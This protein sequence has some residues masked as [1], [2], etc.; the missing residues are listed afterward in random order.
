MY[1]SSDHTQFLCVVVNNTVESTNGCHFLFGEHNIPVWMVE[2][3]SLHSDIVCVTWWT[4]F[5]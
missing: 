5:I 4:L 3:V 1:S 2:L